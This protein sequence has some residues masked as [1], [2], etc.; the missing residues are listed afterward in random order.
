MLITKTKVVSMKRFLSFFR[1]GSENRTQFFIVLGFIILPL[2]C[3]IY[4]FYIFVLQDNS[5]SSQRLKIPP[6]LIES[7]K[8]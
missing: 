4:V 5:V 2:F 1:E 8:K 7:L 6:Q 3:M